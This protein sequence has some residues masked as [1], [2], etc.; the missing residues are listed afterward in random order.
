MA[1][2]I[3]KPASFKEIDGKV[4]RLGKHEQWYLQDAKDFSTRYGMMRYKDIRAGRFELKGTSFVAVPVSFI[5]TYKTIRRKPQV[6]T[7]KDLGFIIG[8]VGLTSDHVVVES[9]S[10]SGGATTFLGNLCKEMH[11]YEI[12]KENLQVT[13][14]NVEMI[15]LKNV[16][17]YEADFYDEASVGEHW[18]DLVLV[19][20]P[21]PEK[22]YASIVKCS[23]PGAFVIAYCPTITQSEKFVNNLPDG[24][25]HDKTV[26]V[27]QRNWKVKGTAVRPVSASIGHT[28]FLNICRRLY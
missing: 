13:K 27:I 16:K 18:A 1:W 3:F 25:L 6:I 21:S 14:E 8:Y 19:D 15:G 28:A 5:D 7:R 9:G 10:G 17:L 2:M 26:E 20:L 23:K 11:S 12:E 24:L 4:R 22:A